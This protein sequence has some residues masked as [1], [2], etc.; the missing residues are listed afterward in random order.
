MEH[1]QIAA[2]AFDRNVTAELVGMSTVQVG[3]YLKR[4]DLFP[5]RP[6]GKGYPISLK[7]ADLLKL[8]AVKTLIEHGFT[9]EQASGALRFS[10][11]PFSAMINDGYGPDREP[12]FAYPGT[13]FFSR[14]RDGQ[15]VEVDSADTLVSIQV[16]C[17]PLF[18]DLWPR[19]R[20]QI[21]KEGASD[22]PPYPGNVTEGIA[23]FEKYIADLRA[24][25]WGEE[26][27]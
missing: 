22:R 15:F 25:R 13:L 5:N 7:L 26:Q 21:E 1:S 11:G 23:A 6:R 18:D 10:R 8:S 3:N 16:R 2:W 17:W 4:Y 19:V 9:P 14:N 12:L 24:E 27:G 20:A